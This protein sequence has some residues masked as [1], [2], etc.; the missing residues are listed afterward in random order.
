MEYRE[1]VYSD[2]GGSAQL[3]TRSF[4]DYSL[5]TL[6][7]EEKWQLTTGYEKFL[8]DYFVME[9]LIYWKSGRIVVAEERGKIVGVGIFGPSSMRKNLWD[10][11]RSGGLRLILPYL[12]HR[13]ISVD[14]VKQMI[15]QVGVR[16]NTWVLDYLAVDSNFR[17][18]GVGTQLLK[19]KILPWI[20]ENGGD[21]V[22]VTV[23][24]HE[25]LAYYQ[26]QDFKVIG[27]RRPIGSEYGFYNWRLTR[28][29]SLP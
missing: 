13:R 23:S 16:K 10:Y 27:K 24:T 29:I 28:G 8:N 4:R 19:S 22:A 11:V 12:I 18:T 1:A 15:P 6:P 3:L 17:E 26:G 14:K 25:G 20:Q 9:L 5:F 21:Q 7:L 2:L